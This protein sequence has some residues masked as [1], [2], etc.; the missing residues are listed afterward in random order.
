MRIPR[1]D[2][3][4]FYLNYSAVEFFQISVI[5]LIYH[6]KTM[7]NAFTKFNYPVALRASFV[8]PQALFLQHH[9]TLT[10]REKL[11]ESA[12]KYKAKLPENKQQYSNNTGN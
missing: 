6:K 7:I 9:R 12:L 11:R 4:L 3:N 2:G 10:T 5:L 1:R 8:R